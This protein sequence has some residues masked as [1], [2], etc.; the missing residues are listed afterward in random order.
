MRSLFAKDAGRFER[1]SF[2]F[3]DWLVDWSKHIAT[4]ETMKRDY[5]R[6]GMHPGPRANKNFGLATAEFIL[7]RGLRAGEKP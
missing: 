1:M 3:E 6:D 2:R 7:G 5:A 4:D